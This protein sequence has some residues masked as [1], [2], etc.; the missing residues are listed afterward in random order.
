MEV[1]CM[2]TQAFY[3]LVEEVVDRL[4]TEHN[5]EQDQ[6]I[7][8]TE[9]MRLLNIKSKSTLQRLRDTGAIKF[10]KLSKKHILYYRMS[11]LEYLEKHARN[12]F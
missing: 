8:D 7:S 1:I 3:A 11:I 9:T 5:I 10:S 4:K 6:W 12:T 2:E